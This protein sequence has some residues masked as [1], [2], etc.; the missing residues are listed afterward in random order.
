MGRIKTQLIKTVTLQLMQEHGQNFS[1]EFEE[2][3][4]LVEQ[5]AN[6]PSKKIRNI[7]AGYI[8]RIKKSE[9]P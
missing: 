7:I 5:Y 8:A 3:K 4:E 9:Q 2:N 1:K 6:V